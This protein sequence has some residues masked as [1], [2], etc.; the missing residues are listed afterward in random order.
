MI[1]KVNIEPQL[2][3]SHPYAWHSRLDES[4]T[5]RWTKIVSS[6]G[7]ASAKSISQSMSCFNNQHNITCH[8]KTMMSENTSIKEFFVHNWTFK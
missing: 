8:T 5:Q 1:I 2:V 4:G 6:S 7:N 3:C